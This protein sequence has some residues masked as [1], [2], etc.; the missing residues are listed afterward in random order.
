MRPATSRTYS[1]TSRFAL[2]LK[3]KGARFTNIPMTF[4]Y[5]SGLLLTEKAITISSLLQYFPTAIDAA[6]NISPKTVMPKS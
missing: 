2:G 3:R 6:E 4:A 1:L 5:S